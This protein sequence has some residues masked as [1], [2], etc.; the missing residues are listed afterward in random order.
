MKVVDV[1]RRYRS[2]AFHE[3]GHA[4]AGLAYGVR[5][6]LVLASI[7]PDEAEGTRGHVT[8]RRFSRRAVEEIETGDPM[9]VRL[10]LEPEIVLTYAGVIAERAF[11]GRRHNWIGASFDLA[12]AGD[13]VFRCVGSDKQASL[14]SRW[15]W[16]VTEEL[17]GLHWG[18]IEHVA[19]ALLERLELDADEIRSVLRAVSLA[20]LRHRPP[21]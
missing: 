3:A 2:T 8:R 14:Y 4:V 11:T 9:R 20:D 19:D 12:S 1:G 7:V 16:T 13:Y 17:V 21:H 15:L 18:D 6:Q 10:R 5:R